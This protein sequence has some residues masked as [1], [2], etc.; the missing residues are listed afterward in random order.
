MVFPPI[1][2]DSDFVVGPGEVSDGDRT[3]VAVSGAAIAPR[4]LSVPARDSSHDQGDRQPSL[5]CGP[6]ATVEGVGV[7]WDAS[8]RYVW[9][10][11]EAA[12]KVGGDAAVEQVA[13]ELIAVGAQT[14]VAGVFA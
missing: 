14:G 8:T 5:D 9:G 11:D 3:G 4:V 10:V 12:Q 6:G 7:R 13:F 1:A 2:E